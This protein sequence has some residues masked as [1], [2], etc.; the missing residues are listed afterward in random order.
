[1]QAERKRGRPCKPGPKHDSVHRPRPELG[2]KTP[3]HVVL[4]CTV[5]RLRQNRVYQH[6]RRVVAKYYGRTDFHIVHI[7]IQTNHLHLLVEAE[8]RKALTLGMQSFAIRAARAIHKALGTRGKIFAYRYHATQIT[9][10][11]Q[12]K[13]ALSYVLNNWRKHGQDRLSALTMSWKLDPYSSAASFHGWTRTF[14]PPTADYTP[15]LVTPPRTSLLIA[16]WRIAGRI[17]HEDR[18]GMIM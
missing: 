7:S 2:P 11:H 10:P 8:D 9:S 14:P 3:V 13:R 1:M 15:I 4:R 17:H 18:P 16:D 5:K 6:L 12:A